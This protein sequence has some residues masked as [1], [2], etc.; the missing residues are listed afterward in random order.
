MASKADRFFTGK[1]KVV[2]PVMILILGQF[3]VGTSVLLHFVCQSLVPQLTGQF[4]TGCPLLRKPRRST[5]FR[6]MGLFAGGS[7][8]CRLQPGI[9]VRAC[10]AVP[11][12]RRADVSGAVPFRKARSSC[13]SALWLGR[14]IAIRLPNIG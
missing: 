12:R 9:P 4:P 6:P 11:I 14:V 10:R 13:E 7:A 2:G 5:K 3:L 1:A 8:R